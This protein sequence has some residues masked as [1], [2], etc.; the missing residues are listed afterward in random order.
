MS[1]FRD[2]ALDAGYR[3]DEA[4]QAARMLEEQERERYERREEDRRS[5]DHTILVDDE[6]RVLVTVWGDGTTTVATRTDAAN[7][8]G[9]PI[10]VRPESS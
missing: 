6:R 5:T 1:D 7:I 2:A 9:P 8:W 4:D 10:T 3:G